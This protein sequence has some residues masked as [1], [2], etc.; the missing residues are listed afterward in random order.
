MTIAVAATLAVPAGPASA[1]Q[2]HPPVSFR[3]AEAPRGHHHASYPALE[4]TNRAQRRNGRAF[5][6]AL[7][8]AARA[9]F[10]T[11]AAAERRGY[12]RGPRA[13]YVGMELQRSSLPSP[14]VHYRSA[15]YD[16]DGRVLDPRRP[17]ALVYW[18]PKGVEPVLV[19]AMFRAP[20][21]RPAP[22]PH[23]L[24]RLLS[25]H[26]H[27]ACDARAEP[28]NALQFA[29]T[30]CP[31]G[32]AHHGA[33]QMTHAW[34]ASE[35]RTGFAGA[36]PVRALGIFVPGIPEVY[37]I[38]RDHHH[39]GPR[40]HRHDHGVELTSAQA[41]VA[42]AWAL[43]L[44]TPIGALL[45]LVHG[46]RA[47]V[48]VRFLAIL[49][50]AGVAFTHAVELGAHV[51]SAPYLGVL[52]CGLIVTCSGLALALAAGRRPRA[53]WAAAVVTCAA[54]IAAFAVSRTIGLP[55][56]GDHVGEW[57]EPT[58]IVA[59]ACEAGVVALGLVALTRAANV[60]DYTPRP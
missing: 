11:V 41:T 28:G 20:A 5:L 25:W 23:G 51:E 46:P 36:V 15:R 22:D 7:R 42:N 24:G 59:L 47:A 2:Y 54:A 57:A 21:S 35:L 60:H 26:A 3:G 34:L 12:R 39:R 32:I 17:E 37:G 13:A 55:L 8:R 45:L 30:Q 44:A 16:R 9:R 52:F 58:A 43:S 56:I 1:Q 33:T 6:A 53:T 14:F 10:P 4:R 38:G 40:A 50:L 48:G 19:G 31:S 27:A 49:G 18:A 29:A